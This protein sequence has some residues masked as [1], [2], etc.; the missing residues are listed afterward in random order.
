MSI[1]TAYPNI[2]LAYVFLPSHF[3]NIN[4]FQSVG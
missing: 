1:K 4:E 3:M 2:L